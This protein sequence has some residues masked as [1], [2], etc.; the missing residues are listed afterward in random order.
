[1]VVWAVWMLGQVTAVRR[2]QG[3][4]HVRRV[5]LRAFFY[6]TVGCHVCLRSMRVPVCASVWAK[7]YRWQLINQRLPMPNMGCFTA[8]CNSCAWSWSCVQACAAFLLL[9]HCDAI[10]YSALS[11]PLAYC[12]PAGCIAA[13]ANHAPNR[14]GCVQ[15]QLL[16]ALW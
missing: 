4:C 7:V 8:T 3:A 10:S 2:R 9:S 1:M 13:V 5:C 6:V 15:Q 11:N 14:H 16:P 12:V